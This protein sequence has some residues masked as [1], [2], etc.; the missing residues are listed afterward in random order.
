MPPGTETAM[1]DDTSFSWSFSLGTTG[2]GVAGATT[3]DLVALDRIETHPL[4]DGLVLLENPE[5]GRKAVMTADSRSILERCREFRTLEEHVASVTG[6]IKEL[7]D[8]P[9]DVRQVLKAVGDAGMMVSGRA[10]CERLRPA[11]PGRGGPPLTGVVTTWERPRALR[12]LLES[13]RENGDAGVL[14]QL[15]VVD[16]SRT[17]QNREE[18]AAIVASFAG[19]L[20]F[21][22]RYVGAS[23]QR[24]FMERIIEQVPEHEEAVRF[25]VDRERWHAMFSV[26]LA[27]NLGL[28]LT[29]G[30]RAAFLDDDILCSLYESPHA[31]PGV[32]FS[33]TDLEADFYRENG[34][35]ERFLCREHRDPLAV[36]HDCLGLNLDQALHRAGVA[37][38][39]A[40]SLRGMPADLLRSVDGDSRILTSALG[41]FGDP[42]TGSL[43]WLTAIGPD[44]RARLLRSDEAL[45]HALRH[46]RSWLGRTRPTFTPAFNMSQSMGFDNR[47]LLPPYFPI[48]RIED[49]LFGNMTR[50]LHPRSLCLEHPYAVP[51]LPIPERPWTPDDFRPMP[52]E[53]FPL[54]FVDYVANAGESCE[55]ADTETRLGALGQFFL[56]LAG[57][58]DPALVRLYRSMRT[59]AQVTRSEQLARLREESAGAPAAWTR[60]L[61]EAVGRYREA[62]SRPQGG[63]AV[64]GQPADL[65]GD[66]LIGFWRRGWSAFGQAILAWPRIRDAAARAGAG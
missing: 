20:P 15:L 13:V 34:E 8:H 63:E 47:A 5:N 11:A 51:H 32:A 18:N 37:R 54:F 2:T 23:E 62:I 28:L 22:V 3:P 46:R 30:Q 21:P 41:S 16:D 53:A 45:A 64:T 43:E 60:H 17:P 61:D 36:H 66:E 4:P 40:E 35:W 29:V 42:G 31:Q 1:T 39:E 27:R 26:G 44:S 55:A 6:A 9:D 10:F 57:R 65:S 19:R 38:V 24:R 59:A 14:E 48:L 58:P 52:D 33:A 12:R 56:E 50:F 25:L 7:R 49:R